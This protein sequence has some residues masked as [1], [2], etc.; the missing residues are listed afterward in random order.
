MRPRPTPP[1]CP[2]GAN[3]RRRFGHRRQRID[4]FA[5]EL[6]RRH[7]RIARPAEFPDTTSTDSGSRQPAECLRHKHAPQLH[8]IRASTTSIPANRRNGVG[9]KPANSSEIAQTRS[10][11][12]PNPTRA[13]IAFNLRPAR[14]LRST[15]L[16]PLPP[17]GNWRIIE[18]LGRARHNSHNTDAIA[19]RNNRLAYICS[20]GAL[21]RHI[22]LPSQIT[23]GWPVARWRR[24]PLNQATIH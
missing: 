16:I 8:N 4:R 24:P 22:P 9:T 12:A 20:S 1:V 23:D 15:E 3:A 11:N 13:P 10:T 2:L 18:P 21:M 5:P 14:D 19:G 17:H 7:Y 6:G